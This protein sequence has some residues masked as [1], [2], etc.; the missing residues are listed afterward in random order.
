MPTTEESGVAAEILS[1][2]NQGRRAMPRE[3]QYKNIISRV[4]E[5]TEQAVRK[6]LAG[7][8][9]AQLVREVRRSRLR[10]RP[11]GFA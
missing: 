6:H 5:S 8:T 3:L 9:L 11:Q 4:G 7:I 2:R 1:D 10:P